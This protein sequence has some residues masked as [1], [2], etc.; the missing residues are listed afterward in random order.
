MMSEH[1]GQVFASGDTA[2]ESGVYQLVGDDPKADK[3]TDMSRVVVFEKG[4][5]IT[6]HPDTDKPAQ[7]RFIRVRLAQR[8]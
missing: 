6:G 5:T 1:L 3:R 8:A 2:P 7:W 4:Q